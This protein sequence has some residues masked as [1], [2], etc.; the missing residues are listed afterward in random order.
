MS[1][2]NSCGHGLRFIADGMVGRLARW[3]R[4]IGND[5]EYSKDSTDSELIKRAMTEARTLLTSDVELYR[6]AVANG[7]DAFL[8]KGKT[9]AERLAQI[10][11]RFKMSLDVDATISRCPTC[12][13]T[14]RP[15]KKEQ[16]IDKVPPS[17]FNVFDEF[18]ECTNSNCGKIYWRGSH[19]NKINE[20]LSKAE[21]LM[22]TEQVG[23]V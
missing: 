16:V 18:W 11:E 13:S 19:W 10:A 8:I 21:K 4:L 2:T 6:R 12:N 1:G 17:T 23:H 20:H 7:A 15:I 3:L 14:I 22:K 5:V 9:E